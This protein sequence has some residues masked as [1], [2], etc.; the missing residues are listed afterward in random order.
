MPEP[1]VTY[2]VKVANNGGGY[3]GQDEFFF[4][5]SGLAGWEQ[6]VSVNFDYHNDCGVNPTG[7][8]IYK[9]DLSDSTNST[10][11]FN[12]SETQNG[13][14]AGG[15]A[16]ALGT[17]E[18]V[19]HYG[20]RGQ[21]GASV[22]FHVPEYRAHEGSNTTIY[23]YCSTHSL[24]GGTSVFTI[25]EVSGDECVSGN[26]GVSGASSSATSSSS[27][28]PTDDSATSSSA[29]SSSTGPTSSSATSS[30]TG[31]TSSSATSNSSSSCNQSVEFTGQLNTLIAATN[32]TQSGKYG[33]FT[34]QS[35][36][37]TTGVETGQFALGLI[38]A[39]GASL[40][41]ALTDL[42]PLISHFNASGVLIDELTDS[43][44]TI[45]INNNSTSYSSVFSG[46]SDSTY[47]QGV[48]GYANNRYYVGYNPQI[49]G[50]YSGANVVS[51]CP[52][53][54][55][56]VNFNRNRLIYDT[57]GT[58]AQPEHTITQFVASLDSRCTGF[59]TTL[60]AACSKFANGERKY[61]NITFSENILDAWSGSLEEGSYILRHESGSFT[62]A[63][64][65]HTLGSGTVNVDR[66]V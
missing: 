62:T 7:M 30:S 3:G 29:T 9:F 55:I 32:T 37:I 12:F 14:H 40:S 28:L 59:E 42:T 21:A 5:G 63:L 10:H 45:N 34:T 51:T 2:Y 54:S 22:K 39:T 41:D 56:Q 1:H 13:T 44:G 35:Y 25:N 57:T 52:D 49:S 15:G 43:T 36:S 38:I 50:N 31:P 47:Y 66:Y 64:G 20:V 18:G 19:Y 26:Y 11:P 4:S 24:M 8:K 27:S 65:K 23:P 6:D 58:L 53:T 48:T 17:G 33:N 16:T 46:Q 61:G 60:N